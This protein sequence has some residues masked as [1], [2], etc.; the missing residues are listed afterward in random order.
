MTQPPPPSVPPSAPYGECLGPRHPKME[1]PRRPSSR[2]AVSWAPCHRQRWHGRAAASAA[3][4]S[5]AS[6]R[7]GWGASANLARATR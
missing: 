3:I 2:G 6:T 5:V 7:L 1:S 4:I